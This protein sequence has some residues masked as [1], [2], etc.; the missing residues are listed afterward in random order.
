MKPLALCITTVFVILSFLGSTQAEESESGQFNKKVS[1]SYCGLYSLYSSMKH[2]GRNVDFKDLLKPEYCSSSEGSSLQELQLAA[3]DHGFDALPVKNMT[4][5]FLKRCPYPVIL[6][7]KEDVDSSQYD[8]YVLYLGTE[9]GKALIFDAPKPIKRVKFSNLCPRWDGIGLVVSKEPIKDSA[10]FGVFHYPVIIILFGATALFM[11]I[12]LVCRPLCKSCEITLSKGRKLSF[13]KGTCN[14]FI[15]I[16]FASASV[17]LCF[18]LFADQGL[19]AK[20]SGV[21]AVQRACYS[22][23]I[24]KIDGSEVALTVNKKEAII[25]DARYPG[26]YEAGHV[27]GAINIP[28]SMDNDA[29]KAALANVPFD[30]P[31][32]VY[33][34]SK[35]CPYANIVAKRLGING[36]TNVSVYKGGWVDWQKAQHK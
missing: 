33:C 8:H 27:E 31:I 22:S 9:G 16:L 35:G 23:F 32:I 34:Q 15:V 14:Q 36:Y 28:M 26:D 10:L 29:R 30:S 4:T 24:P 25:I 19:L 7:V 1:G 20:D 12:K 18:H 6:H 13:L 21:S 2:L 5:H 3:R 11:V 17:G